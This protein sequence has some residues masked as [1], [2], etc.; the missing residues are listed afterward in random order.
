MNA[1]KIILFSASA[2]AIA[3]LFFLVGTL[4]D[5]KVSEALFYE[6][7]AFGFLYEVVGKMPAFVIAVFACI[8]LAFNCDKSTKGKIFKVFYFTIAYCAGIVCFLDLG[9][10]VF[11]S[12]KIALIVGAVLSVPLFL[13]AVYTLK[14]VDTSKL[15][16]LKKWAVVAI[17]CVAVVGICVFVLKNIWARSRYIDVFNQQAEFTPWYNIQRGQ[18]DSFPS[19]HSAYGAM[20]FLLLPLCGIT[21]SFK[22]KDK[23]ILAVAS[24]LSFV[25]MI[26]RISDGHHYL[27]DVTAGY[28]ISLFVQAVTL[29]I[30]YGKKLDKLCFDN[31]RRIERLL[32]GLL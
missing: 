30:A 7:N 2:L 20:L 4:Y 18:N 10:A 16:A 23:I 5:L 27:T 26:A 15:P 1:K 3:L 8:A 12:T 17:F 22:G 6:N 24:I 32:N 14:K 9:E 13:T 21:D 29:F 11:S 28:M 31:T 19:G 25:I